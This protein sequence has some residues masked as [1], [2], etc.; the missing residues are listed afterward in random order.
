M[1]YLRLYQRQRVAAVFAMD[2]PLRW[3]AE[4]DLVRTIGHTTE[5]RTHIDF[6]IIDIKLSPGGSR[7]HMTLSS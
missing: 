1:I 2:D 4:A 3:R 6:N 5:P 7:G